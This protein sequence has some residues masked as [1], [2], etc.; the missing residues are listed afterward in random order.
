MYLNG[1]GDNQQPE[2]EPIEGFYFRKGA[3]KEA[4]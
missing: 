2:K 3:H 1:Y 4:R